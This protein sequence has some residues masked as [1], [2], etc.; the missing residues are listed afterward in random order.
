[1]FTDIT[2]K[3]CVAFAW[4][5]VCN[6]AQQED[7]HREGNIVLLLG[8]PYGLEAACCHMQSE[9]FGLFVG[10]CRLWRL[11]EARIVGL[12]NQEDSKQERRPQ[13]TVFEHA[14]TCALKR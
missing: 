14:R 2:G 13:E 7:V 10:T 12:F 3:R 4:S 1:M 8:V 11:E 9:S 6:G 5:H